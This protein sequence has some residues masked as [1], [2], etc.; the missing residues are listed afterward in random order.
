MWQQPVAFMTT[1]NSCESVPRSCFP[2]H[3]NPHR[4]AISHQAFTRAYP[5]YG[6]CL[7]RL[8]EGI[9]DVLKQLFDDWDNDVQSDGVISALCLQRYFF[10]SNLLLSNQKQQIGFAAVSA[11]SL[12]CDDA[13]KQAWGQEKKKL[14]F[15]LMKI[16]LSSSVLNQ[17]I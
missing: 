1:F 13:Q 17:K 2:A 6:V 9:S 14:R 4:L 5:L 8:Y 15:C 3:T 11:T 7:F 12:M 10:W 16:I